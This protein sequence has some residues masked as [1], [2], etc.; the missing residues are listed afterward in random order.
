[1]NDPPRPEM[2]Y[3]EFPFR[4]EYEINGE[5]VVIE[6][7]L[8]CEFDGYGL[9]GGRGKYRKWKSAFASGRERVTLY[10]DETVEIHYP[11]GSAQY[12]MGD[13]EK[14]RT[15]NHAFPNAVITAKDGKMTMSA[16]IDARQL[17]KKYNIVLISWVHT[18]P[19]VNRFIPSE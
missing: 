11:V 9:S 2:T 4:L 12:Y 8:I 3:G 6:D 17:E 18:P 19:I 1:M 13:L 5:R 14:G 15:V 10:V 7:T 16:S